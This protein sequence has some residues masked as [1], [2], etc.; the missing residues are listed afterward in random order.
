MGDYDYDDDDEDA[1]PSTPN[2]FSPPSLGGGGGGGLSSLFGGGDA[3]QGSLRYQA[4]TQPK[5]AAPAAQPRQPQAA[6][7]MAMKAREV[8]LYVAAEQRQVPQGACGLAFLG[9]KDVGAYTLL[10][11]KSQTQHLARV[12][13]TSAFKLEQT[14]S[15]L[16]ATLYDTSG[17]IWTILFQSEEEVRQ[18][19]LATALAK[20]GAMAGPGQMG[21]ELVAVD[22][23]TGSGSELSVDE[24]DQVGLFYTGWL[25]VVED[26]L[27]VN[28]TKKFDGNV[29][30]DKPFA[31]KVGKGKVI[32]GKARTSACRQRK[33]K[34]E[35]VPA[36]T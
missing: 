1:R 4:P 28:D 5:A 32:Q 22:T 17:R 8:Y 14:V 36:V 33:A 12:S 2:P 15:G 13:F 34:V 11:Y 23:V 16:Y 25:R 19:A 29:G 10:L 3:A 20:Y 18:Y 7:L 30:A 27:Q 6:I 31:V 24:G 9:D 26:P 35:F 21:P